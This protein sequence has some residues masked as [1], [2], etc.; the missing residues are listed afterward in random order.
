ME[1][2]SERNRIQVSQTT[3][4]L[5]IAD[6]KGHWLTPRED[7]I[8]AKGKGMMQTFWCEPVARSASIRTSDSFADSI[9]EMEESRG[10]GTNDV[11]G[12]VA[13]DAVEIPDVEDS[14]LSTTP[15]PLE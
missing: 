10:L 15:E 11:P 4:D 9:L 12:A 5:L 8:N 6:G 14:G 13:E 2:N 1:S 3:A 7:L